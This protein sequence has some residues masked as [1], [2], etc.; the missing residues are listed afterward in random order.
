[1]ETDTKTLKKEKE[2]YSKGNIV[3]I[4]KVKYLGNDIWLL[5]KKSQISGQVNLLDL[6]IENDTFKNDNVSS[7]K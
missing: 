2:V 5:K 3:E 7:I 1:M 4:K 6:I